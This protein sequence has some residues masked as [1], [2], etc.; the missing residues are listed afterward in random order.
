MTFGS[1][2]WAVSLCD[3]QVRLLECEPGVLCE[4]IDSTAQFAG[5]VRP[6]LLFAGVCIEECE[7]LNCGSKPLNHFLSLLLHL[8]YFCLLYNMEEFSPPKQVG[9]RSVAVPFLLCDV[10]GK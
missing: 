7:F 9:G 5:S 1:W 3:I 2:M 10:F 6:S 4:G 8:K